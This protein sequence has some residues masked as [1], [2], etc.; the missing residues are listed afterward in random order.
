MNIQQIISACSLSALAALFVG[1]SASAPN[2]SLNSPVLGAAL[3]AVPPANS[4]PF[5][6]QAFNDTNYVATSDQQLGFLAN[7]PTTQ[8]A[9]FRAYDD[10]TFNTS[11]IQ[12]VS[13]SLP[14]NSAHQAEA[15]FCTE[16]QIQESGTYRVNYNSCILSAPVLGGNLNEEINLVNQYQSVIGVVS[17]QDPSIQPIY[18]EFHFD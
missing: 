1:C 11:Q 14:E 16:Y 8:T 18:Q 7:V 5:Q 15:T 6:Q 17:F 12:P 10:F 4:E 9:S 3:P 13:F 2:D